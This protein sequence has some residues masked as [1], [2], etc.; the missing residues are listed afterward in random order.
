MGLY[1][2]SLPP[3]DPEQHEET[4]PQVKTHTNTY[5]AY[6]QIPAA[7]RPHIGRDDAGPRIGNI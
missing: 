3:V 1:W 6:P 2:S 7:G 5:Q 4:L